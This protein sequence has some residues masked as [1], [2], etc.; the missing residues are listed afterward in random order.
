MYIVKLKIFRYSLN[1][2]NLK[3][4][5]KNPTLLYP[6]T[7]IIT[8]LSNY[9]IL[10]FLWKKLGP[11]EFGILMILDLFPLMIM[12]FMTFSLDQYVMRHYYEWSNDE[13]DY[14]LFYIWRLSIIIST[15]TL[16]ISILLVFFFQVKYFPNVN[17]LSLSILTIINVYVTAIYNVPFSV[18]R[19]TEKAKD[20]FKVKI[21]SLVVYI[22]SII[23]FV[24]IYNYKLQG[25]F[26][27]LI[28]SSV[29]HLLAT[30]VAQRAIF[31]YKKQSYL[32]ELNLSNIYRYCV[33]LIPANLLGSLIGIIERY[34][35]QKFIKLEEIGYYSMANKFVE[36]INQ[37]HGI[38]K[39]SYG[40]ALFKNISSKILT[41]NEFAKN[42][43]NY[44]FPILLS[45]VLIF[46]FSFPFMKTLKI[47]NADQIFDIMFFLSMS[48]LINALQIYLAPGPIVLKKTE[49]KLLLDL[50]NTILVSIIV[51]L[52]LKYFNLLTMLQLK[53]LAALLYMGFSVLI[54]HRYMKWNIDLKFIKFNLIFV[55]LLSVVN[56]FNYRLDINIVLVLFFLIINF[57][58][59]K[60][61][62]EFNI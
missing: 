23:L 61:K 49:A 10:I 4:L 17:Y 18:I 47:S 42:V 8:S 52:S 25:Y 62:Y 7:T 31:V 14:N 27:S 59:Y 60:I 32:G 11:S 58:I 30:I 50:V 46:S 2:I 6:I 33:P 36:I 5:L 35:L 13:R 26:Y 48:V 12:S 57:K 43:K 3:A 28:L 34:F 19:I 39:L 29:S 9:I 40:P 16:I 21:I 41:G 54:T 37:I 45:F 38:I 15:I 22:I 44:I 20:Y 24:F 1:K 53:I 55:S 51:Y 56:F